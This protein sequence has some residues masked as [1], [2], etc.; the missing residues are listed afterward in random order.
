MLIR[1]HVFYSPMDFLPYLNPQSSE[2]LDLVRRAGYS[3]R[4]NAGLCRNVN[5]FGFVNGA[6]RFVICTRN[7]K[8]SGYE[9]GHYISEA[10]YHEAAHVA[11]YCKGGPFWISR[12]QMPLPLHK[13]KDVDRSIAIAS[14]SLRAEH[15]AY[16]MEDKPNEVKY[17]LRKFCF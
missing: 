4:E 12:D 5:V 11:Q 14:G 17:V 15:E 3:I 7:I 16:W 10:I 9:P 2:I 13:L 1:G 6:R 8:R